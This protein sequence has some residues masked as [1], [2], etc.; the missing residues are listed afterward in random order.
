MLPEDP[1]GDRWF[2]L[3]PRFVQHAGDGARAA[4]QEY[5]RAVLEQCDGAVLDLCASWTSHY[6]PTAGSRFVVLGLNGVELQANRAATE[7]KVHD[8]NQQPSLPFYDDASFGVVTCSLSV[9][10]LTSPRE[11]FSE[12]YRVLAPGGV[13]CFAFTN[14]CFPSKVV[15]KWLAPFDDLAHIRLVGSYFHYTGPWVDLAVADVTPPGW[16]TDPMFVVQAR[17]PSSR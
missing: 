2:Y 8:L 5:Y 3:V 16:G 15:S 6:E 13:A 4:L 1:G 12:V 11:L 17:K 7:R 10:Y 9:D 14:R